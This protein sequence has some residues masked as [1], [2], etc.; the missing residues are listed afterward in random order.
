ME[1]INCA[2]LMATWRRARTAQRFLTAKNFHEEMAIQRFNGMSNIIAGRINTDE[3]G[4]AHIKI[5]D[6]PW[7]MDENG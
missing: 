4:I 5:N 7:L 6:I 3:E 2:R 1:P